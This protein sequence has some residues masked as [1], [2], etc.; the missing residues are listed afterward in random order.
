M[1]KEKSWINKKNKANSE[2]VLHKTLANSSNV[3]V[4]RV[5]VHLKTSQRFGVVNNQN[6]IP[7]WYIWQPCW[8]LK[9]GWA[10]SLHLSKSK[11]PL[12]MEAQLISPAGISQTSE[13]IWNHENP[14]VCFKATDHL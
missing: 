6:V 5:C 11:F 10:R 9:L 8:I 14:G 4:F 12:Q 3:A 7:I 2:S 1:W 13:N